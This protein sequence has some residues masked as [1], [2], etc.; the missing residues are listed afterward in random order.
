MPKMKNSATGT[1]EPNKKHFATKNTR[2][3]AIPQGVNFRVPPR[4]K[5]LPKTQLFL[6][7]SVKVF[8]KNAA[9][10]RCYQQKLA[11]DF[12]LVS[13]AVRKVVFVVFATKMQVTGFQ[14]KTPEKVVFVAFGGFSRFG[15]AET[16]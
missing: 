16:C 3:A 5:T 7:F 4:E 8:D 10:K 2:I 12:G 15:G 13:R 1:A 14:Q 11:R 6:L 9:G